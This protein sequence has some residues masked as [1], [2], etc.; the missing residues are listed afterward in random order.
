MLA[1]FINFLLT[2][3]YTIASSAL[4][5]AFTSLCVYSIYYPVPSPQRSSPSTY[6]TAAAHL[7]TKVSP[8]LPQLKFLVSKSAAILVFQVH[9]FKCEHVYLRKYVHTSGNAQ[10]HKTG[11][12]LMSMYTL[13]SPNKALDNICLEIMSI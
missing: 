2:G 7:F 5:L 6:R 1:H 13:V 9:T 11:F 8:L 10:R 12:D 3:V 4:G